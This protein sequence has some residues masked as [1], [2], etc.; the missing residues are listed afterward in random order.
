MAFEK[1]SIL[2][3]LLEQ[4]G[5]SRAHDSISYASLAEL[6]GATR[7]DLK[8]DDRFRP[9][10][11][12]I[13]SV[14]FCRSYAAIIGVELPDLDPYPDSLRPF[15]R[16]EISVQRF[17]AVP[18][19]LFVKPYKTIKAFNGHVKGEA[20]VDG[21]VE[22]VPNSELVYVAERVVFA[23]EYRFYMS[24]GEILGS[25]RYDDGELEAVPDARLVSE[26]AGILHRDD[27]VSEAAIDIGVLE[28]GATALVEINGPWA[29]GFYGGD[30]MTREA[31][32]SFVER[33]WENI[34][35]ASERLQVRKTGED[36]PPL[37]P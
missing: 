31:Y 24:S 18:D 29:I 23:S 17:G 1:M 6:Q 36:N 4:R 33:G 11:V 34:V 37:C 32:L 14:E 13:G 28:N 8:T 7:T 22:P 3:V 26:I 20:P 12:P 30:L 35:A 2:N 21:V 9:K 16:R 25:S 15:L 19:G 10:P 27:L 5:V